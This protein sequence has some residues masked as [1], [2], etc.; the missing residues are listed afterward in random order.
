MAYLR[1]IYIRHCACGR[2]AT[3]ELLNVAN[4]IVRTCCSR[5]GKHE[6]KRLLE[7][8]KEWWRQRKLAAGK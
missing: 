8:E 1:E 5:C 6:L 7:S 4:G 2:K 3:H